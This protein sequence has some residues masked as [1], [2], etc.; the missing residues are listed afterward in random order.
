M[1][2]ATYY[3][4]QIEKEL[5]TARA[6]SEAGNDG[7]ARV[8][9]RRAC[10]HAI[11]WHLTKYPHPGW[12]VD[13]L[14]QLQHVSQDQNFPSDVRSAATRLITK[15][16]DQFSYPFSTHPIDDALIIINHI[17]SVMGAAYD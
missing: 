9:A 17:K 4:E 3:H 13:A 2:S 11:M 10:G 12:G 7:K 16:S 6:A 15:I 5:A 8:C 14:R 1:R